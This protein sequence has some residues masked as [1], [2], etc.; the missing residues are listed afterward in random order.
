MPWSG[1]S[2]RD[3]VAIMESGRRLG[4][5]TN[6]YSEKCCSDVVYR[7]MLTCWEFTSESRPDFSQVLSNVSQC[8]EALDTLE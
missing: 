8:R 5:P 6:A 1:I 3:L 4:Q 7:L 2:K